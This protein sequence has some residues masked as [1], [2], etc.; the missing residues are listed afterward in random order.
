MKPYR[1]PNTAPRM[2]EGDKSPPGMGEQTARRIR[3]N[4]LN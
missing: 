2:K 1:R 4:F 3:M